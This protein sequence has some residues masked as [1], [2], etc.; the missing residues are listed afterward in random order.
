MTPRRAPGLCSLAAPRDGINM[1]GVSLSPAPN[2]LSQE[3]AD[4]IRTGCDNFDASEREIN[5]QGIFLG[6][7]GGV[8]AI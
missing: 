1:G 6:G 2:T 8:E 7:T 4:G 3:G 5:A